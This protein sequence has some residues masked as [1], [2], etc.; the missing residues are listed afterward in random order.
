[1]ESRPVA[2]ERVGT[3]GT[4]SVKVGNTVIQGKVALTKCALV[5]LCPRV[6]GDEGLDGSHLAPG[7][8]RVQHGA[9]RPAQLGQLVDDPRGN[10]GIGNPGHDAP[11]LELAQPVGQRVAAD[12]R[13]CCTQLPEASR[14]MHQL[15][16]D[17]RGPGAAKE[18]QESGYPAL[19]YIVSSGQR[20]PPPISALDV[21]DASSESIA[22]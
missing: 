22:A 18:K 6:M 13:E 1:M 14:T 12:A 19:G 8:H 7:V 20:D 3:Q 11:R 15:P 21:T 17:Q 9:Q 10:L 2:A 4:L 5:V 16:D